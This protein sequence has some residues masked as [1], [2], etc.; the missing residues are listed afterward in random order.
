[1]LAEKEVAHLGELIAA[2]APRQEAPSPRRVRASLW[3]WRMRWLA[4]VLGIA[5][6]LAMW[7]AIKPPWRTA[8]QNASGTLIAQAPKS[9]APPVAEQPPMDSLSRVEPR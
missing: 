4:P 5:A 3:D 9:E 8:D 2:R 7:F 1:P 6:V